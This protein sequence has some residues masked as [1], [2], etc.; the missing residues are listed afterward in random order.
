MT[1]HEAFGSSATNWGL[2]PVGE[3][4]KRALAAA[5]QKPGGKRPPSRPSI[6]LGT[7]Q[8]GWWKGQGPPLGW[9]SELSKIIKREFGAILDSGSTSEELIFMAIFML[10]VQGSHMIS[11]HKH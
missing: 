8:P 11:G 1:T 4:E 7:G 3:G 9:G 6:S 10:P 2:A 5:G